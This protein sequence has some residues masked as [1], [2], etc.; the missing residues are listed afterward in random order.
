MAQAFKFPT[1]AN[2]G[3]RAARPL[4]LAQ[5]RRFVGSPLPIIRP[6]RIVRQQYG[7][8][9]GWP[10]AREGWADAAAAARFPVRAIPLRL[11][12]P[13]RFDKKFQL[14]CLERVDQEPGY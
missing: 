1:E 4:G 11:I 8:A 3:D 13:D 2:G 10:Q 12:N 6:S 9:S 7:P 14:S 5:A